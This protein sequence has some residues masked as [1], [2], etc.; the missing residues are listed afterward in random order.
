[1][2]ASCDDGRGQLEMGVANWLLVR[3]LPVL[4]RTGSVGS[5]GLQIP[6]QG[7]GCGMAES[8]QCH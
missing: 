8:G 2:G 7:V 5:D 3:D 4:G 6:H 1:M